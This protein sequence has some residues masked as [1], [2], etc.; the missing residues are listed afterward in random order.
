MWWICW[1]ESRP[2]GRLCEVQFVEGRL[3]S[4]AKKTSPLNDVKNL[5]LGQIQ[6]SSLFEWQGESGGC[7]KPE[8][9][10]S[11]TKWWS[12]CWANP[13]RPVCLN[14]VGVINHLAMPSS[15]ASPSSE[16]KNL[17]MSKAWVPAWNVLAELMKIMFK[18]SVGESAVRGHQNG[19]DDYAKVQLKWRVLMSNVKKKGIKS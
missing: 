3:L 18:S 10:P 6:A 19:N 8:C 13:K 2:S 12:F 9:Q 11:S 14:L 1:A 4:Q 16:N 15:N 17:L 5:W 7:A